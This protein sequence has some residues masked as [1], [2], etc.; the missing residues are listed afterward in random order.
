[1]EGN[2]HWHE[3]RSNVITAMTAMVEGHLFAATVMDSLLHGL[4]SGSQGPWHNLVIFRPLATSVPMGA[5]S[6]SAWS[7]NGGYQWRTF[8]P[9]PP[10][11]EEVPWTRICPASPDTWN[12]FVLGL[13]SPVFD[14]VC[15][16][17]G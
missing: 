1:M 5:N 12:L 17:V 7:T 3:V 2:K 11:L 13:A 8:A 15:C 9:R 14:S 4:P 10:V 6:D 16:N